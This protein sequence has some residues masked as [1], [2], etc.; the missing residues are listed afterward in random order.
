MKKTGRPS[1]AD[2]TGDSV[3]VHVKMSPKQYDDVYKRAGAARITVPEQVRRDIR[4]AT[5]Q[6]NLK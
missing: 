2:E 3:P 5:G 1:L 4:T 6:R